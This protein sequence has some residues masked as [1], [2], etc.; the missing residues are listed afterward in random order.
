MTRLLRRNTV[1]GEALCAV[2]TTVPP[3]RG[4]IRRWRKIP[5]KP[6]APVH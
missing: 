3:S 5:N 4:E 6:I 1:A 2:Q